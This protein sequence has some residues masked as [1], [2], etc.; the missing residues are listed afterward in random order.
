[1]RFIP[2][3]FLDTVMEYEIDSE[4]SV[5]HA[6]LISVSELENTAVTDLPT[7][8]ESVDPDALEDI[9]TGDGNTHISF[10]YSN[11]IIEIYNGEYLTIEPT[12]SLSR[13]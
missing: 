3:G 9:F 5:S 10:G 4:E 6:V 8:C 7:L 12:Q 11:S 2:L 1:M 13:T